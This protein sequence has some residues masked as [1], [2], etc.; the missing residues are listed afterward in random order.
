MLLTI[1]R[2]WFGSLLVLLVALFVALG[3]SGEYSRRGTEPIGDSAID[4]FVEAM[5]SGDEE[6][7]RSM[8]AAE[9]QPC[10]LD[11]EIGLPKCRGD[12]TRG[13]AVRAGGF[14]CGEGILR[15]EDTRFGVPSDWDL[16]SIDIVDDRRGV[17][18]RLVFSPRARS[19]AEAVTVMIRAPKPGLE[20]VFSAVFYSYSETCETAREVVNDA[21]RFVVPPP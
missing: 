6:Y 11:N 13:M 14:R 5:L 17:L 16:Y 3:C 15:F 2:Q 1:T 7:I 20:H 19:D 8:W 18:Y 12:E 21:D 9:P 10:F 4:S